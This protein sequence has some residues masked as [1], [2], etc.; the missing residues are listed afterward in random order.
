MLVCNMGHNI[1]ECN[2]INSYCSSV[3][4]AQDEWNLRAQRSH[5]AAPSQPQS[6]SAKGKWRKSR[7][8][9]KE[10][11]TGCAGMAHT[12]IWTNFTGCF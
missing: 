5:P 3:N 10:E 11:P 12:F 8:A 7:A 9:A 2:A 4:G 6:P 1:A